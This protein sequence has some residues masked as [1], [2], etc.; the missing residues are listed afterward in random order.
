M[1]NEPP[2]PISP[3]RLHDLEPFVVSLAKRRCNLFVSKAIESPPI[4]GRFLF[5]SSHE[6][7]SASFLHV[8]PKLFDSFLTWTP[9]MKPGFLYQ[10]VVGHF[11]TL[12]RAV[13]AQ[14]SGART[15]TQIS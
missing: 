13:T 1:A 8:S 4:V 15:T 3:P 7:R 6:N 2:A 14:Q 10:L 9:E 12:W 11:E 5:C